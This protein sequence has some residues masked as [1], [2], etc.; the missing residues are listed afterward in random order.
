MG[1]DAIS[2]PQN[3]GKGRSGHRVGHCPELSCGKSWRGDKGDT[4]ELQTTDMRLCKPIGWLSTTDTAETPAAG[5]VEAP[6]AQGPLAAAHLACSPFPWLC[7]L[8]GVRRKE[9]A[10]S[11]Q[12][13]LSAK[14]G[15]PLQRVDSSSLSAA[16][17]T[18]GHRCHPRLSVHPWE[19]VRIAPFGHDKRHGPL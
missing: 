7:L 17:R 12:V 19:A 6:P 9:S 10:R 4:D 2:R 13:R 18:R 8:T 15:S 1:S 14:H 5:R 3:G 16:S 11:L